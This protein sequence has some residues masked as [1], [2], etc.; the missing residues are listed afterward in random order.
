M[1]KFQLPRHTRHYKNFGVKNVGLFLTRTHHKQGYTRT[2]LALCGPNCTMNL[3]QVQIPIERTNS[4]IETENLIQFNRV[5]NDKTPLS[6]HNI[7]TGIPNE[8]Q[9]SRA[10]VLRLLNWEGYTWTRLAYNGNKEFHG[11]DEIGEVVSNLKLDS[12]YILFG[13]TATKPTG[14]YVALRYGVLMS[15]QLYKN[16]KKNVAPLSISVLLQMQFGSSTCLMIFEVVPRARKVI[17]LIV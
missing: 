6:N 1:G 3:L 2:P 11:V 8:G 17:P 16:H 14:H 4:A 9:V 15:D 10:V 12:L 5:Q 7:S 13:W